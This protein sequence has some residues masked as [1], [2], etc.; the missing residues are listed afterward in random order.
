MKLVSS[1]SH[2]SRPVSLLPS[3]AKTLESAIK[4]GFI[5]DLFT[6]T[7]RPCQCGPLLYS[8][9]ILTDRS[10]TFDTVD[11]SLCPVCI[12]NSSCPAS[13]FYLAG[14]SF[15]IS[16]GGRVSKPCGL[17]TGIPQGFDLV[18]PHVSLYTKSFGPVIAC[19]TVAMPTAHSSP[20]SSNQLTQ[21]SLH[22]NSQPT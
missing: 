18:P 7:V 15:R 12:A 13:L 22:L 2:I 20:S 11:L 6:V 3:L 17:S 19:H 1:V 8:L 16:W 14:C 21:R 5:S 10:A 9:L 4:S